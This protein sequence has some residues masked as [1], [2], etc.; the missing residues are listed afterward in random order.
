[1]EKSVS[2]IKILTALNQTGPLSAYKILNVYFL[3]SLLNAKSGVQDQ[4]AKLAY[5]SEFF[6][7]AYSRFSDGPLSE[8]LK[9]ENVWPIIDGVLAELRKGGQFERSA[10]SNWMP[11]IPSQRNA[12]FQTAPKIGVHIAK[13]AEVAKLCE[14][15]K[16]G[17]SPTTNSYSFFTSPQFQSMSTEQ[18]ELFALMFSY[19]LIPISAKTSA[20][21]AKMMSQ[22]SRYKTPKPIILRLYNEIKQNRSKL[23]EAVNP[24]IYLKKIN[25]G[26]EE[27]GYSA[28]E[29]FFE[30]NLWKCKNVLPTDMVRSLYYP[31]SRNVTAIECGFLYDAFIRSFV[32][33]DKILIV[34]PSPDF[35]LQY[36]NDDNLSE[37]KNNTWFSV[38]DITLADLYNLQFG[39]NR[40]IP[41]SNIG[42]LSGIT[43]SLIFSRD[44]SSDNLKMAFDSIGI[45]A[46]GAQIMATVPQSFFGGGNSEWGKNLQLQ[47]IKIKN[48]LLLPTSVCIH[49]KNCKKAWVVMEKGTEDGNDYALI[50]EAIAHDD[51]LWLSPTYFPVNQKELLDSGLTPRAILQS[52]VKKASIRPTCAKSY[53]SADTVF[54]SPEITVHYELR[55]NNRKNSFAAMAY[56]CAILRGNERRKRGKRLTPM[57]NKGLTA[58]TEQG[59]LQKVQRIV[60]DDQI[61]PIVVK[62]VMNAYKDRLHELSLKTL[63]LCAHSDLQRDQKYNFDHMRVLLDGEDQALGNLHP[64]TATL[65]EYTEAI[66]DD[67]QELKYWT[68]LKLL[69]DWS[70]RKKILASNPVD[71]QVRELSNRATAE[72]R[73]VRDALTKK[74]FSKVEEQK[75]LKYIYADVLSNNCRQKRYLVDAI[76]LG[77]GILFF[78][79]MELREVCELAWKNFG[80]LDSGN[81]YQLV[82]TD[83]DGERPQK[84]WK[85]Y[86]VLPIHPQ[87][88]EM[89]VQK[90]QTMLS[91][92]L[93]ESDLLEQPILTDFQLNAMGQLENPKPVSYQKFAG[94]CRKIIDRMGIK[95]QVVLLPD[96]KGGML[97]DLS[98]YR[99]NIFRSNF[100]YRANHACG[101]TQG[102]I[103]YYLGVA[104]PDT[105][106]GHYCDFLNDYVQLGMA[107]KLARWQ[108]TAPLNKSVQ[109]KG[110]ETA[111]IDAIPGRIGGVKI[112]IAGNNSSRNSKTLTFP[113]DCRFGYRVECEED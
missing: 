24:W 102:E 53:N 7:K 28:E 22:A 49:T 23:E 86:R 46:D 91:Q 65:H 109:T 13:M 11:F 89:L 63:W 42:K 21:V 81:I 75:L 55:N 45:C 111:V 97:T 20:V 25:G 27:R 106:S 64:A 98:Y 36:V 62:D 104:P 47:K 107:G 52:E 66:S 43:K 51:R 2:V 16:M 33:G 80:K 94:G 3:F 8:L 29:T 85:E 87:L 9:Q 70:I 90:K 95:E 35:L 6:Q 58:K 73:E 1:M 79:G 99:G 31:K 110:K 50:S 48:A 108:N 113:V 39:F 68:Q 32:A 41:F 77:A 78:T 56:Y 15:D 10:L 84:E 76:A 96:D 112:S 17:N 30:Q 18:E 19:P 44:L 5:S 74:T 12:A 61:L 93:S 92:G 60:Y 59:L 105:F 72:Q 71:E 37:Y 88:A 34:N 54:F 82:I 57:I 69:L 100:R 14:F 26:Y 101:F 4:S 67:C 40:A 38:T 103:S 83:N